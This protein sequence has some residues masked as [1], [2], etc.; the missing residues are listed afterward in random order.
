[1]TIEDLAGMIQRNVPTKD[2]MNGKFSELKGGL[3]GEIREVRNELH[4]VNVR[5][6]SI[7]ETVER[8]DDKDLPKPCYQCRR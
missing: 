5:L 4:E 1:M 3:K 2:E 6:D 7:Q 8:I